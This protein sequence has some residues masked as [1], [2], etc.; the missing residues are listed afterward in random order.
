MSG[1]NVNLDA[2]ITGTQA[3]RLAGVSK[4]LIRRWRLLGHL[5]PADPTPGR[6]R[7]RVRDVLAAER[8]TRRAPQSNRAA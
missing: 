5:Q 8:D 1:V 3:A 4:Q 2:L 6:P 7:Y